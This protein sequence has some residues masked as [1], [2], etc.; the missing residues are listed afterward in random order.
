MLIY[1]CQYVLWQTT[2]LVF[3]LTVSE[4]ELKGGKG[5]SKSGCD[6]T[7]ARPGRA[8]GLDR[9]LL[10]RCDKGPISLKVD[11]LLSDIGTNLTREHVGE[12]N[13]FQGLEVEMVSILDFVHTD[14]VV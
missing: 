9:D 7:C 4:E 1:Q 5:H 12:H 6:D 10:N 8:L 13:A 3:G 11:K 14:H 2:L